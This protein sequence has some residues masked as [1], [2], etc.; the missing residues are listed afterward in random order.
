[1]K[2]LRNRA[3]VAISVLVLLA[4]AAATAQGRSHNQGKDSRLSGARAEEARVS[5]LYKKLPLSFELNRGQVDGRV[6]F[7][8]RGSGI[9]VFLTGTETVLALDSPSVPGARAASRERRPVPE[10]WSPGAAS[11]MRMKLVGGNPRPSLEGLDRLPGK[12]NYFTGSDP[13]RWRTNIPT[14]AKVR[15][16]GVYPGVDLVYYGNQRQLEY[17]FV[18]SGGADPSKIELA[19][20]GAQGLSVDPGGDLVLRLPD[21]E[22][23]QHK[24]RVYQE[25]PRG[26]SLIEGRYVLR[27]DNRVAF[28]VANYD[29]SRPLVI[30]PTLSFSTY[31]GGNSSETVY[32]ISVHSGGDIY[33]AGSTCSGDFPTTTGAYR[34]SSPGCW[35]AFVSRLDST[36]STLI[37]STFLGQTSGWGLAVDNEGNAYVTGVAVRGFPTTAGAFRTALGGS[38]DA[39]ATKLNSTGNMLLYSTYLGGSQSDYGYAVGVDSSGI[40]VVTGYTYSSDYPTTPNAVQRNFGGG[41]DAFVTKV[42]QTGTG[43]VYSTYLGGSGYDFGQGLTLDSSSRAFVTGYA[44]PGFPTTPGAYRAAT[45]FGAFLTKL[46]SDGGSFGYSTY[47]GPADGWGVAVDSAGNAYVTGR[48]FGSD[49]PT[50]PG[51]LQT[52]FGGASDAFVTEVNPAGSGLVYSTFLGGSYNEIGWGIVLDRVGNVYVTGE[53]ESTNFPTVN[54]LQSSHSGGSGVFK[55]GDRGGTWTESNT[56]LS[57]NHI[58]ALLIDSR[59]PST[60]YAAGPGGAVFKS[61]NSGNTWVVSNSGISGDVSALVQDGLN[62]AVL[63]AVTSRGVYRSAN[64]GGNWSRIGFGDTGAY[65]L[66]VDPKNSAILYAGTPLGVFKSADTG[67]TWNAMNRGLGEYPLATAIAIDP[68]NSNI[69]YAGFADASL[70]KSTDGGSLWSNRAYCW[71]TIRALAIDPVNPAI[72]YAADWGTLCKTTD[73]GVGWK[74]SH[75]GLTYPWLH[76]V[77]IDRSTP[78]TL[79]AGT[80]GGGLFKSINSG[81]NWSRVRG[82]LTAGVV[83]A[84]AV[85]PGDSSKVYA[86]TYIGTDVFLTKL[87]LSAGLIWYSTFLGGIASDTGWG[88]AVDSSGTA[89][90]SGWTESSDFP[91]TTGSLRNTMSGWSEGFVLKVR[92]PLLPRPILTTPSPLPA[93]TVGAAYSLQL[94]AAGGNPPYRWAVTGSLPPGLALDLY[95][96][97]LSGRPTA[98]G[99]F[100]FTV[101]VTDTLQGA[102][103]RNYTLTINFTGAVLSITTT[104]L[105]GG[106]VGTAY[107]ATLQASGGTLPYKW[108]VTAGSLPAGLTLN[109]SSGALSGTPT[110]AGSFSFTVQVADSANATATIALSITISSG[111]SVMRISGV[112]NGASFATGPV[113]PGEIVTIFGFNF[114]PPTLTTL[115]LNEFGQ[116][117]TVLAETRVLFDWIPAPLIYVSA[118]QIAAIVPYAVGGQV[119]TRVQVEYKGERT[120]AVT[121]QVSPSAPGLF[122]LDSSG[123]G[124]GAFLNQDYSVNSQSNPAQKNTWVLLYGT[125]EGMTDP[126][127][128]DGVLASAQLL[129]KPQLPV[130]VTIGGT[131]AEVAY[132]GSAPGNVVGLLQINVK[133]P[134]GAPSGNAVPVVVTIGGASSQAGVTLA[135]R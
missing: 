5:E 122:T 12:S 65:A 6:K 58:A 46:E 81:N 121:L 26:R 14:Y 30:D 55:S 117:A 54:P 25:T 84:V 17:D 108:S 10:D 34:V 63:Y 98:A 39:F 91:L 24:P 83:K 112:V 59:S 100:S 87:N 42:N 126:Q 70:Y 93:G 124:Q 38:A 109:Q 106:T 40:A 85:D 1:M 20:E 49:Y 129:P 27:A 76:S 31:L 13:A 80:D 33:V 3:G 21:G 32:G 94:Q 99:L 130:S 50:T 15:A 61:T 133:V 45:G 43:L 88:I 29:R 92:E 131:P 115:R 36:G 71:Y 62:A 35:C 132:A 120:E 86:G 47:L 73:A 22:L 64:A 111:P 127:V 79:Y 37:Y 72:V 89:Y 48:A 2:S 102:G 67:G 60:L 118:S 53:T 128:A 78:A 16:R 116:V 105:P 18:V 11:V 135:I 113:S 4:W 41:T 8:S 107:S 52:A 77:T 44:S 95:T 125:G 97:L 96:G 104:S 82:G 66:A 103:T 9:T 68:Q 23:R 119:S 19:F 110:T 114:G 74:Y 51:A 28:Q 57:T 56:G 90:V 69:L 7:L 134:P 75:T 123:K 101:T